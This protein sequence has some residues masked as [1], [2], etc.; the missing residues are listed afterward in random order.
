MMG[1]VTDRSE[2]MGLGSLGAEGSGLESW[3]AIRNGSYGMERHDESSS[4]MASV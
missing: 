4:D 1:R 2:L 3:A